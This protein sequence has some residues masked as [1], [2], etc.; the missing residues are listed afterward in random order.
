[1]IGGKFRATKVDA[2]NSPSITSASKIANLF[3]AQAHTMSQP[4]QDFRPIK[5]TV[6][7]NRA[8]SSS[9]N[10][11]DIAEKTEDSQEGLEQKEDI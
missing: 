5:A 11:P 10:A 3:K 7:E 6:S 9:E 1:M 2:S 8:I 4:V